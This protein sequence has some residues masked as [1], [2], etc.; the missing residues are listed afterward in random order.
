MT[1]SAPAACLPPAA[2]RAP[3]RRLARLLAAVGA[4][5]LLTGCLLT[6][7]RL[8]PAL[9][10]PTSY[11]APHS[12]AKAA[13]PSAEWWRGFRSGE[14]TDLMEQALAANYDIAA[15]VARIVQADAQARVTGAALLPTLDATSNVTRSGNGG[16]GSASTASSVHT[17][18]LNASYVVDFWGRNRDL[19]RSAEFAASAS[20]FDRELIA[21]TTM[22]SVADAYFLV[23]EAQDRIRVNT[24][25][26]GCPARID[27]PTRNWISV[28]MN[29]PTI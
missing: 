27:C 3:L 12:T 22:V 19:L 25:S 20:R 1:V 18:A 15:A 7:D 24:Q 8:D 5:P 13:L 29:S 10:I 17:V 14:L 21:L 11:R 2:R 6:A 23:L 26:V 4:M 28:P 16:G 9:D